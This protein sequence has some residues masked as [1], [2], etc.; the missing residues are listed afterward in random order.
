M[1]DLVTNQE[2]RSLTMKSRMYFEN[3]LA[4]AYLY[5]GGRDFA[6]NDFLGSGVAVRSGTVPKN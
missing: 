2:R 1:K 4:G 5:L 6:C 3:M